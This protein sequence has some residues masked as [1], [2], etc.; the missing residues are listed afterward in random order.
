MSKNVC[1]ASR[2]QLAYANL[3]QLGCFTGLGMMC[4]T[5]V[6]Y[7]L[8]VFEPHI[9]MEVVTANWH[10]GVDQYIAKTGSPVGWDWVALLGKGDYMNFAGL[11]LLALLTIVC[12]G[13]LVPAYVK[14]G[15][16]IY[17]FI[18]VTEIIVLTLAASGLVGGGGH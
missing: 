11:A 2:E 17:T 6:L 1:T 10:L 15:D 13:I 18:V 7:V 8:G 16:K 12:Y 4:V 3:L 9:S 14:C 5:Y